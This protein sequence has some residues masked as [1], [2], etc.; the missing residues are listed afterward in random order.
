MKSYYVYLTAD[1]HSGTIY[2]GF[3]SDLERRIAQ[4]KKGRASA[5]FTGRYRADIL[6]CFEQTSDA[7]AAIAR[8]KQ[9]KGWTDAK[10]LALIESANP[11]WEDLTLTWYGAIV[12][13]SNAG[14]PA[15]NVHASPPD[16][17][18]S[19]PPSEVERRG[20]QNDIRGAIA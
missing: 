12:A 7:Y 14:N 8:E 11:K 15:L 9:I 4:H 16:S 20:A 18:A 2:V 1:R 5:G 3:T 10:K 6:V 13:Q 17:F 19:M